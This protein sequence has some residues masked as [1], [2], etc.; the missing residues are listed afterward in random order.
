ML[1]QSVMTFSTVFQEGFGCTYNTAVGFQVRNAGAQRCHM[2]K[3]ASGNIPCAPLKVS[4][5]SCEDFACPPC[6]YF[7][8]SGLTTLVVLQLMA[9][10]EEPGYLVLIS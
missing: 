4:H 6:Q 10:Q 8:L 2:Q 3:L 7:V 9:G 1:S 5:T